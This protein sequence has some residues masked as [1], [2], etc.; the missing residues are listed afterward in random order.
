MDEVG[1]DPSGGLL[2]MPVAD[3]LKR[4]D[5]E[6]RSIRTE[7][8]AGLWQAQTPQM[9]RYH[10]LLRALRSCDLRQATDEAAAVEAL[11]FK[12]KL[13]HSDA[14]NLKVTHAKDLALAQLILTE[15]AER[16]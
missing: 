8:R 12:P 2:A 14:T 5:D 15:A 4:A 13:V 9:F 7:P 6:G 3:T 11:G 1:E 10:L 16:R